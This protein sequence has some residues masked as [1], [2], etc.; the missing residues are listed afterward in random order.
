MNWKDPSVVLATEQAFVRL[1]H[2]LLGLVLWEIV[3]TCDYDID[4]LRGRRR[5]PLTYWIY[6]GCRVTMA[7][8]MIMLIITK[9]IVG[10]ENCTAWDVSIYILGYLSLG[11]ASFLILL[12]VFAVWQGQ[13]AVVVVSSGMWALSTALNIRYISILR[14]VYVPQLGECSPVDSALSIPSNISVIVSDFGLLAIM[15][16]GILKYSKKLPEEAR[17]FGGVW[18]VLW[19][20]GIVW[21]CLASLVEV[22]TLVLII[23]SLNEPWDVMFEV[24]TLVTLS[25]GATRMYRALATY[26]P[27]TDE[28][29]P[30]NAT[31]STPVIEINGPPGHTWTSNLAPTTPITIDSRK[32]DDM[33]KDADWVKAKDSY[34]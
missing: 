15:L 32:D 26:L 13:L 8:A 18:N 23:L 1:S 20:Q 27:R 19:Q 33:E 17:D 5:C 21:L 31:D 9:D 34:V 3:T 22:P 25:I 12:R 14:A 4:V 10:L 11:L 28:F 7:A 24:V 30:Q 6:L 2:V 29:M 16:A